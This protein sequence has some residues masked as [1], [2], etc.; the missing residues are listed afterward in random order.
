MITELRTDQIQYS[1]TFSKRG[2]KDR[3]II[4]N[5]SYTRKSVC[6][7]ENA[8]GNSLMQK[9]RYFLISELSVEL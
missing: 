6:K 2:Y 1:P 9:G 5:Y 3:M 7:K 4:N 8:L